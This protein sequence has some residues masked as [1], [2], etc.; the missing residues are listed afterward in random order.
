MKKN[1]MKLLRPSDALV[2]AAFAIGAL[3]HSGTYELTLY[4]CY[5]AV[6]LLSLFSC[7]GVRIAFALQPSMRYVRGSVKCALL[8]QLAGLGLS[9]A[10]YKLLGEPGGAAIP[11]LLAAGAL[12]NI[13]HTF[14][15][16]LF[17]VGDGRSATLS[18]G[19]AALF[20]AAG[21]VLAKGP[22]GA[23]RPEWTLAMTGLSALSAIAVSLVMG[24][25]F[26]GPLNAAVLRAAPRAMLQSLLYP[27]AA[28]AALW[29]FA[30]WELSVGLFCGLILYELCRTPFRRSP[31]ESAPLNRALAAALP[32]S[33]AG[34]AVSMQFLHIYSIK[35]VACCCCGLLL[36][37]LCALALYAN[38]RRKEA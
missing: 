20:L 34:L 14:Y 8:T 9:F 31:M 28:G 19:L 10:A 29:V 17:A 36:A 27:L 5:L 3:V 30:G 33:A 24:D 21:I 32:L 15:E 25:G 7:R 18:H 4:A 22:G 12:L 6:G 13:E 23:L 35:Y 1:R 38:V 16:Y 26:K 2:P 37:A 11:A